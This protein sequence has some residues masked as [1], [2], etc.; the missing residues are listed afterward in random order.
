MEDKARKQDC[1]EQQPLKQV[2]A[3]QVGGGAKEYF[4]MR[5]KYN[6]I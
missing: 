3:S 6:A 2:I 5:E 4:M 1:G